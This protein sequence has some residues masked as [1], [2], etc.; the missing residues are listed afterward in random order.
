MKAV[1]K[2]DSN[3]TANLEVWKVGGFHQVNGEMGEAERHGLIQP[4]QLLVAV[5]NELLLSKYLSSDEIL[6][7]IKEAT[8]PICIRF[9]H[10]LHPNVYIYIIILLYINR[11][12]KL[13]CLN[14]RINQ[15]L[16]QIDH[17]V[18]Q[19]INYI[20]NMVF[21]YLFVIYSLEPISQLI[22]N[23]DNISISAFISIFIFIYLYFL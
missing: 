4:G 7:K 2:E 11:K 8:I 13:I 18:A 9:R 15:D 21:I 22:H 1:S 20:Y 10:F 3:N 6:K 17:L 23:Y 16:D 19:S 5:N 12:R 14:Y